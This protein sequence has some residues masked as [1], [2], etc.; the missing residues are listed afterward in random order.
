MRILIVEDEYSLAD[1]IGDCLK[2]ENYYI[3]ISLNGEEGL[4]RAENVIYD[5]IIL[6][7]ML[8]GIDGIKMVKLLRE[9]GNSVPVLMLTA[10]TELDDKVLGLETGADDYMTKPFEMRELIARVRALVRRNTKIDSDTLSFLDLTLD[11]KTLKLSC[12]SNGD[13]IVLG[14]KEYLLMEYLMLNARQIISKEQIS[15]RIWGCDNTVEY[16]N[17]EVYIS[18]LRKKL[19]FMKSNASIKTIRQRGYCLQEDGNNHDTEI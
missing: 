9:S 8:P 2:K 18:F 17:V 19:T 12:T 11:A 5:L 3:D 16:N 4:Y 15:N 7:V 1:M 14:S 10:K 6:D 13:S